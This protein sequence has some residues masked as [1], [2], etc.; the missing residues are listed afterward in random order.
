MND[1]QS[2]KDCPA[3]NVRSKTK[4]VDPQ[5]LEAIKIAMQP[6]LDAQ[7]SMSKKLDDTLQDLS[8]VRNKVDALEEAVQTS[9]DRVDAV[10]TDALPSINGHIATISK[11][12]AMRQLD[13]ELHRR[14]GSLIITGVKGEAS[15]KEEDTRATTLTFAKDSLKMPN[16]LNTR[17]SAC[18]RLSQEA[19]AGIYVRFTDLQ[20]RNEW[21]TNAKHLKDKDSKIS[22]SPDLPP[23]LRQLK[24]DILS[25]RKEFD[26]NVSKMSRIQYI[27]QWPYLKLKINGQPD[28]YPK[29]SQDTIV[30]EFLGV[31]PLLR[32]PEG[33]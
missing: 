22:I 18:H 29:I 2:S 26:L 17:L 28:R 9:S 13:T 30:K 12:L 33:L 3:E 14:K 15:E 21:L 16:A 5:V 1:K 7:A 10:V 27:K 24:K 32:V 31:T 25:Q 20:E 11:A 8:A 23:V 4:P 19:D 6:M